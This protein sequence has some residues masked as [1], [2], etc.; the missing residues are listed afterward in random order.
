MEA[1]LGRGNFDH[2]WD[3]MDTDGRFEGAG[4]AAD[5]GR[6]WDNLTSVHAWLASVFKK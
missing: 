5:V 1:N 2:G 6:H 4:P 3:R